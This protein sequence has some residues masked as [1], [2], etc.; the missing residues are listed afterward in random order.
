[1]NDNTHLMMTHEWRS[2][3]QADIATSRFL[4][5]V[6]GSNPKWNNTLWDSEM[7]VLSLGVLCIGFMNVC[8]VSSNKEYIL[9][10]GVFFLKRVG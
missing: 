3:F 2:G 6:V 10:A 7:I 9:I 4:L 8:K 5:S 1:M